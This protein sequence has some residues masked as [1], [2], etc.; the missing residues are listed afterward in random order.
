MTDDPTATAKTTSKGW[1]TFS[2]SS[3]L[4]VVALIA[5]LIG[6][7]QQ[8]PGLAGLLAA[9]SGPALLLTLARV[10]VRRRRGQPVS[11]TERMNLF[12]GTFLPTFCI[13]LVVVATLWVM[14]FLS[15]LTEFIETFGGLRWKN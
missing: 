4:L 6:L 10:V 5:I 9:A 14:S 3:L 13:A 12:L 1:L 11:N 8:S 7:W 15:G 2:L